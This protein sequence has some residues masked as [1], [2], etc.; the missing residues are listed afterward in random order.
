[1]D[2]NLIDIGVIGGGAAGYFGALACADKFPNATIAIL[3]K[4]RQPLAKVRISG[5]G[6]CN[7]THYSFDPTY[8]MTRYPR[9]S[10]FLR[11]L[12][13]RFQPR[14]TVAWFEARGVILKAESDGR[15]FP[16]TNSSQTIIDCFQK[17]ADKLGIAVRLGVEVV[18]LQKQKHGFKILTA[19]HGEILA[20]RILIAT[21][22]H[23]KA[24]TWLSE[25]GHTV[26]PPVPSL[27]TFHIED[28]RIS[29]LAGVAVK[30]V[31]LQC[32]SFK[33]KGPILIT[34][35]G[36][37]G[38]ATLRLSAWAARELQ[39]KAY[40]ADLK[41]NWIPAFKQDQVRSFLLHAK[42]NM[43][44]KRVSMDSL[45]G[46]PRQLW[47]RLLFVSGADLEMRF[48]GMSHAVLQK[49]VETLTASILQIRGKSLHKEEFVTCGGVR[50]DEIHPQSMESRICPGVYFAGEVLDID[51]VT[52]GFN[53]QSAWT[54]SWVAAQAMNLSDTP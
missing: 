3:E 11:P 13:H 21:G 17:E 15:M 35:W 41:I 54:T 34:H 1:M 36:L 31:V 6:R 39:E 53:F 22:S 23:A 40:Q 48:S 26:V 52:G 46:L 27:F 5:G 43:P 10:T 50:L 25:L 24:Y 12:L 18:G 28:E 7:T 30:E 20:K 42:Q 29:G 2:Q 33:E 38:P 8:L 9:G 37:S 4:T 16:I 45:F 44:S 32:G 51:G 47:E 14:D 49:I 19:S